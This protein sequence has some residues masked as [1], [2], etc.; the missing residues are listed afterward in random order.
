MLVI[1]SKEVHDFSSVQINLPTIS[2]KV[3]IFG[4]EQ[5][6][7]SKVKVVDGTGREEETHVTVKFG[8]H[9]NDPE[10]VKEVVSGFGS[11]DIQLG[12]ISKFSSDDYDV[13]KIDIKSEQIKQLNKLISY[14]LE[15]TDTHPKYIPHI[16]I[17]YVEKDSCDNLLD[18]DYFEGTTVSVKEVVFSP[19]NGK[20]RKIAL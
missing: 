19:K 17:S 5:I 3:I 14:N 9:T 6:P 20:D 11:F 4:R 8:L 10:E 7:D 1:S 2:K 18:N 15:C 13:I 16:T 12:K